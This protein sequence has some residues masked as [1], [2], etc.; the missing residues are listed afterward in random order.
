M[1][2]RVASL[3]ILLAAACGE[4]PPPSRTFEAL[5]VSLQ[6]SPRWTFKAGEGEQLFEIQDAGA[7]YGRLA[8]TTAGA[9][10]D[11][12][13]DAILAGLHQKYGNVEV[14]SRGPFKALG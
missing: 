4:T 9:K 10:L 12:T 14:M 13:L 2:R 7:F 5:G 6:V 3:L 1:R 8:W 11:V